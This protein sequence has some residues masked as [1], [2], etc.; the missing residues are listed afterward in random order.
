MRGSGAI[1]VIC[2]TLLAPDPAFSSDQ[3]STPTQE[4]LS[5]EDATHRAE[6]FFDTEIMIEGGLGEPSVNR[7]FW[8]FPVCLGYA[9]AVQPDPILVHRKK[10]EKGKEKGDGFIFLPS[11]PA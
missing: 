8:S 9:G 2:A 7:E 1:F 11:W 4:T 5:R 10:K 3:V 6:Q